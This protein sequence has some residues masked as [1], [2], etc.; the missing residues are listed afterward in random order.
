MCVF[1][2]SIEDY[3]HEGKTEDVWQGVVWRATGAI[4][5]AC[6]RCALGGVHPEE[7]AVGEDGVAPSKV[8]LATRL[9]KSVAHGKK[10][11]EKG[12]FSLIHSQIGCD[13]GRGEWRR[14]A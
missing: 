1:V 14:G 7:G 6:P 10:T 9:E 12:S 13:T 2:H 11:E 3:G 5:H 4:R 8:S